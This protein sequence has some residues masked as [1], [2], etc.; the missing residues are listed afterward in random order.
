MGQGGFIFAE[1]PAVRKTFPDF[2]KAFAE[3]ENRVIE[4]CDADWAPK[5]CGFLTPEA[6]EYGRTSILPEVFNG[7]GGV[8]LSTWRQ[9]LSATGQQR[10]L[11]GNGAG[12]VL[13]KGVKIAWIGIAFPNPRINIS[14]LKW[15]IS[16]SKFVRLD[17]EEINNY[18]QPAV[19]FEKGYVLN[20]E[21]G[22]ELYGNVQWPDYQRIVLLGSMFYRNIDMV[23]G[24]CGAA[25][26]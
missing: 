21:E 6:D 22:F 15:Q 26:T 12:Y 1:L 3:L 9:Y 17:L 10:I 23:L 24:T 19:V 16:D 20:E 14:E 7:Y 2:Q 18:S 11:T 8:A 25:I 4:K 13:P 5:R